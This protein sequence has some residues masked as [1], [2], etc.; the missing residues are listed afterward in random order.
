LIK[1]G[2]GL[3]PVAPDASGTTGVAANAIL[4]NAIEEP[5]LDQG[6]I[7]KNVDLPS[8]WGEDKGYEQDDRALMM[9][10]RINN[11]LLEARGGEVYHPIGTSPMQLA[12][13]SDDVRNA[14]R[15]TGITGEARA[16]W[17]QFNSFMKERYTD[18]FD[19]WGPHVDV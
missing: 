4:S 13:D 16:N 1:T 8:G 12:G 14:L 11:Q 5:N 7:D 3:L 2:L 19:Y 18:K 9:S 6:E 10:L 17:D 15:D